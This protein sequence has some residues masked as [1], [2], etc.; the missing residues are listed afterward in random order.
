MIDEHFF[1]GW[2]VGVIMGVC[3]MLCIAKNEELLIVTARY[4]DLDC[5]EMQVFGDDGVQ[6]YCKKRSEE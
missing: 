2:I 3:M 6:L 4:K 1:F 5:I